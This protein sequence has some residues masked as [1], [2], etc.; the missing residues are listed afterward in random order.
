MLKVISLMY[1]FKNKNARSAPNGSA[2]DAIKVY[3][4]ADDFLCVE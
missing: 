4:N 2:R 1:G 3:L